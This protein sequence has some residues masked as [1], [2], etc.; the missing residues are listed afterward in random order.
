MLSA[1]LVATVVLWT[2]FINV[3]FKFFFNWK[4]IQFL[5]YN[6]KY[7]QGNDD[8]DEKINDERIYRYLSEDLEIEYWN[9]KLI[10]FSMFFKN[11]YIQVI[12]VWLYLKVIFL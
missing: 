9:R 12:I 11:N 4:N 1:M 5:V 2:V 10:W 8:F 6:N 3:S 7:R